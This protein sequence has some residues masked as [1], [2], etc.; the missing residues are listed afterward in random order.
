[1]PL[2]P[3]IELLFLNSLDP[4]EQKRKESEAKLQ[5]LGKNRNFIYSLP[6]TYMKSSDS[7]VRLIS[8]TYFKNAVKNDTTTNMVKF[9]CEDAVNSNIYG[10]IIKN[11]IFQDVSY[12]NEFQTLLLS[13]QNNPKH[14][15]TALLI[16]D[17]YSDLDKCKFS[18][19][20]VE[21]LLQQIDPMV[22]Y[23][24]TCQSPHFRASLIKIY[25]NYHVCSYFLQ[26]DFLLLVIKQA[27]NYCDDESASLLIKI[28]KKVAQL[29]QSKSSDNLSDNELIQLLNEQV[30][31][32]FYDLND[33]FYKSDFFTAYA[34]N[35]NVK[36][37]KK[38]AILFSLIQP[39][40]IPVFEYQYIDPLDDLKQKYSFT[41]NT[42]NNCVTL[43]TE[44]FKLSD[45]QEIILRSIYQF[46]TSSNSKERYLGISLFSLIE[47]LLFESSDVQSDSQFESNIGTIT[48]DMLQSFVNA[49]IGC[50]SDN[51]IYVQSQ[52]LYTLQFIDPSLLKNQMVNLFNFVLNSL[53]NSNLAIK[54]NACLCLPLFIGNDHINALIQSNLN[55]IIKNLIH[56]PLHLEALSDTLELVIENYD[57]S[58]HA[59]IIC[60]NMV[61]S[62]DLENIETASYIRIISSLIITLDGGESVGGSSSHPDS[63]NNS[64]NIQRKTTIF[65]IYEKCTPLMYEI[66]KSDNF[67]FFVEVIDLLS[68]ILY[69]FKQGDSNMIKMCMILLQADPKE[70][71]NYSEE[72]TYLLDNFISYCSFDLNNSPLNSISNG[73]K[74][75][76]Q[77]LELIIDF[78]K[79]LAYQEEDY[80]FYDD[81]ICACKII[82]SLL[83]NGKLN[84]DYNNLSIILKVITDC[85]HRLEGN[86]LLHGLEVIM[87]AFNVDYLTGNTIVYECI[88]NDINRYLGDCNT[89]KKRFTR[90]HDKKIGLLF[91]SNLMQVSNDV[92]VDINVL[93]SFFMFL[94]TTYDQAEISRR[95]LKE[96]TD[97]PEQED[98]ETFDSSSEECPQEDVYF[99]TPLDEMDIKMVLQTTFSTLKPDMIGNKMLQMLSNRD[100]QKVHM[101]IEERVQQ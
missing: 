66:L 28:Y 93:I 8:A 23:D 22:F 89:I 100:K 82:E 69:I 41:E 81:F 87:N 51:E 31:Q 52:A 26:N 96:E 101:I 98:D 19:N 62:V 24:R 49:L 42:Y 39:L 17:G 88:K 33:P 83:L 79:L 37:E 60:S 30:V 85:Y 48:S 71:I 90:V 14:S 55:I 13:D 9:S 7:T 84:S 3:S 16:L 74:Y 5:E 40:I 80:L 94:I 68:N 21:R 77:P 99:C 50:L 64:K 29:D 75:K 25:D 45:K 36:R 91:C 27:L 73:S 34:A 43:F 78:V 54:T 15:L 72:M 47:H 57:I 70:I 2:D 67:D 92:S 12:Y 76:N 1:M 6:S 11:Q 35:E 20:N 86:A 46:M 59:L 63:V 65:S 58:E 44:I 97:N 4:N 56:N 18:S 61:E 10:E 53:N 32:F 38:N 95:H